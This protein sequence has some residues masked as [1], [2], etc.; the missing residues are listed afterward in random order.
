[1][2]GIKLL[3]A[4]SIFSCASL[5]AA[6]FDIKDLLGGSS[7]SSGILTGLVEGVFMKSDV[8]TSE[9]F[10]V[11]NSDKPAV[12]FKSDD[13]LKKAGGIAAAAAVESKLNPYY[14]QLGLT[15]STLTVNPDSTFSLKSKKLNLS[16]T[17]AKAA[18]GNFMFTVKL[19]NKIPVGQIPAYIQ[20]TS[21]SMDVMFDSSKLKSLLNTISKFANLKS[22]SAVTKILDSYDGLYIGFGLTKTGDVKSD[23]D[24]DTGN[25]KSGAG[26]LLDIL[27]G[28]SG[29]QSGDSTEKSSS[30]STDSKTSEKNDSTKSTTKS[31]SGSSLL[32]ILLKGK[33]KK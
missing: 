16:G 10:G 20:K 1:M 8:K 29:N 19:F 14:N 32:D 3:L 6:A 9:L 24:T 27:K 23:S 7:N 17:I 26:S 2:T 18:D 12:C 5:N 11:W 21:R 13:L 31:N 25:S 4:A 30:T 28:K 22:L 15:N 33:T